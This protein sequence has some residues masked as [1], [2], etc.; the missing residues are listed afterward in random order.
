MANRNYN[1]FISYSRA[2]SG[3][4]DNLIKYL[5]P[6]I[7]N[8]R[9]T[10]WHDRELVAGDVFDSKIK[11]KL[12]NSDICIFIL[13][14]DYLNSDYCREVEEDLALRKFDTCETNSFRI[15]PIVARDCITEYT[16]LN[17]FHIPLDKKPI[18]DFPDPTK[19]YVAIAKEI[20]GVLDFLD[21]IED[22]SPSTPK[23]SGEVLDISSNTYNH[24]LNDLGF[25]V[26]KSGVE[27]I[28]L[29][30]LFVYPD[31]KKLNNEIEKTDI[32]I[33]SRKV[34]D[35]GDFLNKRILILGDEQSGKT[36]L[37]KIIYKRAISNGLFPVLIEGENIKSVLDIEKT[38]TKSIE[39][40]YSNAEFYQTSKCVLIIDDINKSPINER[41]KRTLLSNLNNSYSSIIIISDTVLRMQ[42]QLMHELTTF[43]SYEIQSFGSR[44]KDE[45]IERWNMLG[46]Q[47]TED[48]AVIQSSHD[49]LVRSVDSI[50]M[51]NIVPSKPIFVIMIL[52]ILET[53]NNNDYSLTSYGHCYHSLIIDAFN[54]ASIK[55]DQFGDYFNYL[56][57][58]AFH[59]YTLGVEK[60]SHE[61]LLSFQSKYSELYFIISHQDTFDKILKSKIIIKNFNDEFSFQY[62]YLFYF[63][64]AKRITDCEDLLEHVD[65]LCDK[66]HSEKHANILIFITHHTNNKSVI[67][68]IV[69][70]VAN[71]FPNEK[72]AKLNVTEVSFLNSFAD[73]IDKIVAI[74]KSIDVNKERKDSLEEKDRQE[75]EDLLENVNHDDNEESVEEVNRDLLDVNRSYRA[76]EILGQ[77]IRNRKG[78]LQIQ[79][80]DHLGIEAYSVGL[81]YLNYYLG[82]TQSMQGEIIEEIQRLITTKKSWSTERISQEARFFY[83]ADSTPKCNAKPPFLAPQT[84]PRAACI[85]GTFVAC[86]SGLPDS[87]VS[88]L[89]TPL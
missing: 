9:M 7:T 39:H 54:R 36:T 87:A 21:T 10:I 84:P 64:V 76:L 56:S 79:D 32:F 73:K 13:S 18:S 33:D 45:I 27:N 37:S 89:L 48:I 26:Q 61:E 80:L 38:I 11:D 23:L 35:N 83:W 82:L 2:D 29:D 51:K 19:A 6:Y 24:Y 41:F 60:I 17:Q 52:Q 20:K 71:I 3:V 40:Q 81:R 34:I 77:I 43:S 74:K 75:K 68:G 25:T 12:N 62:K 42:D 78:S 85:P 49:H 86:C 70:K 53:S 1:V 88:P 8:K 15:I 72:P 30:D 5:K 31:F 47:E 65:S 59:I 28:F 58:L 55:K 66:L 69:K 67:K 50:M 44:K 46:F 22:Y 16:R 63:F 57:E 4:K 14:Q